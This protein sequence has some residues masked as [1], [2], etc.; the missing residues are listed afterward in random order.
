MKIQNINCNYLEIAS[1]IYGD[2]YLADNIESIEISVAV[3][4]DASVVKEIKTEDLTGEWVS[5]ITF[6]DESKI[7]QI[8]L[9]NLLTEVE[10]GLLEDNSSFAVTAPNLITIEAQVTNSLENILNIT[11][12]VQT[13]VILDNQLTIT[14][15]GL[16]VNLIVNRLITTETISEIITQHFFQNLDDDDVIMNGTEILIKPS[17]L[18]IDTFVDGIYKVTL[19]IL[20]NQSILTREETC[21]F[22]DCTIAGALISQ[23]NVE[24]CN[25]TDIRTLMLHYGL[26][27]ASNK[28]CDC[29]KMQTMFNFLIKHV[30][31]SNTDPCGC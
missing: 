22:M 30:D 6:D 15:S 21:Y 14:F 1:S 3:N 18:S 5:T 8:Y 29:D 4:D 13:Y 16:S 20:N 26:R 24:E 9:K 11:G 27:V 19:K 7:T 12:V 17:F 10:V 31:N 25:E 28:E 23:I 2:N